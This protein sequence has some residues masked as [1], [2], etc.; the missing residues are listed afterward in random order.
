MVSLESTVVKNEKVPWR[1]IEGEAILVGV[2]KGEVIH[3]NG[4]AAFIWDAIDGTR[5][6]NDIV[7]HIAAEF[8]VE[9]HVA[10]KDVVEF[11]EILFNNK[12]VIEREA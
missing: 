10:E 11:I 2:D 5:T 8:D 9:K 6:I 4:P 1:I 7:D 12:A 3:L